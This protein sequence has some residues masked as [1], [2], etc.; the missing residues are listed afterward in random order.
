MPL[1]A[2]LSYVLRAR[3][4]ADGKKERGGK[5]ERV[6]VGPA[7]IHNAVWE[8]HVMGTKMGNREGVVVG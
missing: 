5:S 3:A 4:Q 2:M 6:T 8:M 1:T 7:G